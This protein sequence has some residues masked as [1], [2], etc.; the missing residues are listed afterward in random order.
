MALGHVEVCE[1]QSSKIP[2]SIQGHGFFI[3]GVIL[4]GFPQIRGTFMGGSLQLG[5]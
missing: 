3:V 5:L 2:L 1:L 4:W